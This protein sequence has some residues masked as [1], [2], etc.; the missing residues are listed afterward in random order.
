MLDSLRQF[1]FVSVVFRLSLA[2]L[3]GG[4]VGYGRSKKSQPAGFRTYIICC[5]GAAL[6]TLSALYEYEM[7][8]GPWD[9]GISLKYDGARYSAAVISGIGFLA[10][11]SILRI[12]H[13]QISGLTTAIGLFVA[14]CM[15][16]AAGAGFYEAV[17]GALLILLF[18]LEGMYPLEGTWKRKTRYL[19]MLVSFEDITDIDLITDTL[20]AEEVEIS[21]FE[22]E[23][24]KAGEDRTAIIWMRLPRENTSHS[25]VLSAVAELPCVSA[26]QELIS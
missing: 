25:A 5:I 22:L 9:M 12:A 19:T 23:Q 24:A 8:T 21:E 16:I 1:S 13:Q 17:I 3:A 11:G 20:L 10:A 18:V 15:G 4:I 26:V 14:V 2:T 6:A 7:L